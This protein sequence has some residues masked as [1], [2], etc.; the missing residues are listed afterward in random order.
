VSLLEKSGTMRSP[1]HVVSMYSY[2]PEEVGEKGSSLVH[3]HNHCTESSLWHV[4]SVL[5]LSALEPHVSTHQ[6][7]KIYYYQWIVRSEYMG[8]CMSEYVCVSV[9]VCE[10]TTC[11]EVRFSIG[12]TVS[13][14]VHEI[15]RHIVIDIIV[16]HTHT[17][18]RS[19]VCKTHHISTCYSST[20]QTQTTHLQHHIGV[21][22]ELGRSDVLV[23]G[24]TQQSVEEHLNCV[25]LRLQ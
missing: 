8:V 2:M 14:S 11:V 1:V 13:G 7:S 12:E 17:H 5:L 9:W 16:L 6:K 20:L 15:H 19:M 25:H 23:G 10:C 21:V 24:C 4:R 18:A 3:S 22:V